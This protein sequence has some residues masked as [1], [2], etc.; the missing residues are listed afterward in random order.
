M[1]AISNPEK[2]DLLI[3]VIVNLINSNN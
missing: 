1:I 2:K 3:K